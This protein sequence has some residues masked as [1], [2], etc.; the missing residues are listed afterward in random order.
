MCVS[1]CSGYVNWLWARKL[2]TAVLFNF[3]SVGLVTYGRLTISGIAFLRKK[4][5]ILA[6]KYIYLG[7][8]VKYSLEIKV[9]GYMGAVSLRV[10]HKGKKGIV[11]SESCV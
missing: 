1:V 11:S 3:A 10:L 2:C 7:I 6:E 5:H 4:T 8:Q 9:M